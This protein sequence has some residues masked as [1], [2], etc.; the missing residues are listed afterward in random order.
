MPRPTIALCCILK[1][2]KKNIPRLLASVVDCFDEIH[3]TD[4]GSTD[5]SL[6]LIQHYIDTKESPAKTTPIYLHHFSWV[7]D[8]AKARNASFSHSQCDY[9]AWFDLDDRLSSAKAFIEFRNNTMVLGDFWLATYHYASNKEG[10]PTCS[11]ARERVVK[12]HLKFEWLYFLHEGMLPKSEIKK[13]LSVQYVTSWAVVHERTEDDL[14][15]DKSR[16]L[17]IF[18]KHRLLET[19]SPRMAYYYGK[20]LFEA[21][22][23]LD[24][25]GEL[26]KAIADPNLELHDRIMGLQYTCMAAMHLNQPEK[27]M[28]LAHNGL[29]LAPN[30]A[31]F[32]VIVG[33]CYLKMGKLKEAI[34]YF[35]AAIGC[36][37]HGKEVMQGPIFAHEDS[38]TFYPRLQLAKA[39]IHTE[40]VDESI[41]ILEDALQFGP[42][43]DVLGML[44]EA[45]N[46]KETLHADPKTKTKTTDLVIS[47]PPG[48]PY[49]WDAEIYEKKGIGGSETAAVEMAKHLAE[50]TGRKILIYNKREESKSFGLVEYHSVAKLAS[51]FKHFTPEVHIAWR[52][53]V[54]LT[55]AKTYL[56]C[57][58]L[59]APQTEKHATFDKLFCLSMFHKNYLRSI[60]SVPEEKL[61]IT[62]NGISPEKFEELTTGLKEKGKVIFSSSPDRG[63]ERAIKV[64][65]EVIKECPWATLHVYYGFDNMLKMKLDDAVNRM[66]KLIEDRPYVKFHGNIRQTELVKEMATAEVW[67]YPTNFLETFCITALEALA[68][69]AFPIVRAWGG[70]KDTLNNA[71]KG[72]CVAIESDCETEQEIKLYA[73]RTSVALKEEYWKLIQFDLA[74][75][76]WR[77]VAEEWVKILG[78]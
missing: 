9:L 10:V 26:V 13:D 61:I 38:Y 7:D 73:T 5:G 78:L 32:W 65:D 49:E 24:A 27:A 23:H 53:N 72:L 39:L 64:M 75:H 42:N 41:R 63:L 36:D 44:R 68:C 6:E 56:W 18:E 76:S 25:F 31:E 14:K 33:D 34:P 43:N 57:H 45:K 3:L 58:D 67:L 48:T 4:T 60:F 55:D 16:N 17:Q 12:N 21:G 50:L 66:R 22:K 11:F 52:H 40:R 71:M 74:A 51:Y 46:L 37:Y 28:N 47:C 70:L 77:S 8:F 54:R 20:E 29:Q 62:R 30:R 1:N 15:Q 59:A 19:L 69:K 2:E 35:Q